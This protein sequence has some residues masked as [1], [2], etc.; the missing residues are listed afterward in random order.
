MAD[1][2]TGL[3]NSS[4][5]QE[6]RDINGAVI[7]SRPEAIKLLKRLKELNGDLYKDSNLLYSI[8]NNFFESKFDLYT[9][10]SVIGALEKQ[11][12]KNKTEEKT[13]EEIPEEEIIEP[14][15]EEEL[16]SNVDIRQLV[17]EYDEYLKK[18]LTEQEARERIYKNY[19]G[20]SKENVDRF[21]QRQQE[22][23]KQSLEKIKTETKAIIEVKPVNEEKVAKI[24]AE[25]ILIKEEILATKIGE[26][27]AK[28]VTNEIIEEVIVPH[29]VNKKEI[30]ETKLNKYSSLGE[31]D[32]VELSETFKLIDTKIQ[33][34][35]K[36]EELSKQVIEELKK[37][38]RFEDKVDLNQEK[39]EK[40]FKEEIIANLDDDKV[41]TDN[42]KSDRLAEKITIAIQRS[43]EI[44]LEPEL[45]TTIRTESL[46]I[47]KNTLDWIKT[48]DTQLTPIRGQIIEEKIQ[49]QIFVE[50][51]NIS[52]EQ[53]KN[54]QEYSKIIKE[55]YSTP[56]TID[57]NK[58][59]LVFKLESKEIN[60]DSA[61]NAWTDL[62]GLTQVLKMKPAEFDN[63][64][65]RYKN[66]KNGMGNIK[67]PFNIKESRSLDKIVRL[68][69]NPTIKSLINRAQRYAGA[70]ERIN[71]F[72]SGRVFYERITL[73]VGKVFV[74]KIGNQAVK[75]FAENSLQIIAKNGLEKG[76]GMIL[77]GILSGGVKA[78]TS[79]AAS[80]A[81]AGSAAAA[82]GAA[83]AAGASAA[84]PVV[85]WIVAAAIAAYEFVIKPIF[86]LAGK[87]AKNLNIEIGLKG[88]LQD[89]FGKFFGGVADFGLKLGGILLAPQLIGGAISAATT[90]VGPIIICVIIGLFSYQMLFSNQSSSLVPAVSEDTT[91]VIDT[92]GAGQL[93]DP[94]SIRGLTLTFNLPIVGTPFSRS[95]LVN[96]ATSLVGLPYFWGGKYPHKGIN[97]N[98]G[99]LTTVTADDSWSTG[100]Q[101]PLGL[102]CSGFVDWAYY[103]L[104]G[105]QISNGGGSADICRLA[106]TVS[107][108]ELKPGD[109]GCMK[110]HV[111]LYIGRDSDGEPLFVQAVG[112][113]YRDNAS[114]KVAGQV[115]IL[116]E[117]KEYNGFTGPTFTSYARP[118]VTF[119][120]N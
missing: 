4:E 99:N 18:G 74:E 59:E 10:D 43:E 61:N 14:E 8:E 24:V 26:E 38:P 41:L 68:A 70:F 69:D 98:W 107:R 30:E 27:K 2:I 100:M 37:D 88:F 23:Y 36:S 45:I 73:K 75:A 96:T 87:I 42:E 111:S 50:N 90:I 89:T 116:K 71:N 92:G 82:G 117:G 114:G 9:L 72:T 115:L 119:S 66:I 109:V 103:Q 57:A 108:S 28:I 79:A 21:I 102:D 40:I 106:T 113:R 62:K 47:E 54:I 51:K 97:P 11:E 39:I 112:Q 110:G 101:I 13:I 80:G 86:K 60:R 35:N 3:K 104:I 29:I 31:E 81:A 25:E 76:A 49:Q 55:I 95:D 94:G 1:L 58:Q 19:A 5:I 44:E 67:L 118:H 84:V 64:V 6:I 33:I 12:E 16:V 65:N 77:K 78:G 63:F 53:R 105:K 93:F 17:S 91:D 120:D 34:E 83:G 85:G 22:I 32:K 46:K 56:S 48:N 52:P 7:S 20:T 15:K